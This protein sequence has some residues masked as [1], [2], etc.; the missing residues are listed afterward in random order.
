[1]DLK[2]MK[3]ARLRARL[4]SSDRGAIRVVED[5]VS[6]LIGKGVLTDKDLPTEAKAKIAERDKLRADLAAECAE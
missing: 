2:K 5:L 6:T 4:R 3:E 1:M